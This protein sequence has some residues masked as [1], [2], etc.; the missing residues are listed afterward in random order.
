MKN[1]TSILSTVFSAGAID[2]L[3]NVGIKTIQSDLSLMLRNVFLYGFRG[4]HDALT[5]EEREDVLYII[6]A[7]ESL[8]DLLDTQDADLVHQLTSNFREMAQDVPRHLEIITEMQL[9]SVFYTIEANGL[10]GNFDRYK[11]LH[12]TCTAIKQIISGYGLG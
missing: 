8:K 1:Q 11:G 2:T 3:E 7:F 9:T 4:R 5:F 10:P 12:S 6:N